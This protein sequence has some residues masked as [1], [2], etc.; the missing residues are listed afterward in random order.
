MSKRI[1]GSSFDQR[2]MKP[3][4][5]SKGPKINKERWDDD[6]TLLILSPNTAYSLKLKH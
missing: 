3:D 6:R 5:N 4:E 1:K 2:E